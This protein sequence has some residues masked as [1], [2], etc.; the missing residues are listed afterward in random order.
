SLL[1]YSSC[2]SMP[3]SRWRNTDSRHR[4]CRKNDRPS[5]RYAGRK[6]RIGGLAMPRR[7]KSLRDLASP[8]REVTHTIDGRGEGS[9][10]SF[11][12]INPSTA[13]PFA[14]C[15]EAS[16]GQLERA[17]ASARH[18]F[19]AWSRLAPA[20]RR[21]YLHKLAARVRDYADDLATVITREQGKPLSNSA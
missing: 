13:A 7:L 6:R 12:V 9:D 14:R 10:T 3:K 5:R 16:E 15:P 8:G 2:R 4:R 11:E 20:D 17:V 21:K 18:A 1:V 19:A